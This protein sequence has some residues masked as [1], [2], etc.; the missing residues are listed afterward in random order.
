M[1]L[2]T[3]GDIGGRIKTCDF[4]KFDGHWTLPSL[5]TH[6]VFHPSSFKMSD[7]CT[8][9]DGRDLGFARYGSE[10]GPQVFYLHG[11]P[12]SRLEGRCFFEKHLHKFGAG[13]ISVER[14]GIGLSS[15]HPG[16]KISDH[17]DDILQL[18]KHLDLKQWWVIGVSGGCPYALACARHHPPE[19]LRGV[20]ICAGIGP[21]SFGYHDMGL[22]T[23]I[24]LL[25]FRFAPWL[26]HLVY[27][28]IVAL[29]NRMSD[30]R[31]VDLMQKNFKQP[32]KLM[33]VQEQD[34][35]IFTDRDLLSSIIAST[36]EHYRQGFGG[37]MQ[38]GQCIANDWDFEI[39]DIA[40]RPIQLWHGRRDVNCPLHMTEKTAQLLGE[41]VEVNVVD[42]THMSASV[43]CAESILQHLLKN[44]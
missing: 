5:P 22:G 41:G 44:A 4:N 21:Y 43:N 29:Q 8:L 20:A 14:P 15:P 26:F 25:M 12:G 7:A 9:S 35:E 42:E 40:F 13:L 3:D 2:S 18:S 30:E 16:R 39:E 34:V 23:K 6:D 36:K 11:L 28:P 31:L 19:C 17:A 38:D 27:R 32:S 10:E 37:F 1:H 33:Q 24:M